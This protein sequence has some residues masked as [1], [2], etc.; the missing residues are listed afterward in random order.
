MTK[1]ANLSSWCQAATRHRCP[2]K[3]IMGFR[4]M[5]LLKGAAVSVVSVCEGGAS[6]LQPPQE[7]EVPGNN[8]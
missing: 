4:Q 5:G 6:V 1:T 2:T 7:E 8:Q 3:G